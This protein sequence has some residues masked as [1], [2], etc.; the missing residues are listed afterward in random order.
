VNQVNNHYNQ[1]DSIEYIFC[2][3]MGD[4]MSDPEIVNVLGHF[5]PDTILLEL[6]S[7]YLLLADI[8]RFDV[9]ICNN[10]SR[11]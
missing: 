7:N 10:K 3:T 11:I 1:S 9:E 2:L 4:M 5:M 8:S 6:Y